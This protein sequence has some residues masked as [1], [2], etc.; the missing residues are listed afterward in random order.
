MTLVLVL[1]ILKIDITFPQQ[2]M[3]DL[4]DLN[5]NLKCACSNMNLHF[6]ILVSSKTIQEQKSWGNFIKVEEGGQDVAGYPRGLRPT[7][8][9]VTVIL[10]N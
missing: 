3:V 5:A 2:T 1:V 7:D 4:L 6:I 10:T 9:A 8:L